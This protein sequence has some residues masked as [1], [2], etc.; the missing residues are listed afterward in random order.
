MINTNAI[1]KF[2]RNS[3]PNLAQSLVNSSYLEKIFFYPKYQKYLANFQNQL[4]LVTGNDGIIV[5]T[6][7]QRGIYITT[8]ESLAIPGTK[9]FIEA[10]NSLMEELTKI[11]EKRTSKF[12]IESNFGQLIKYPEIFSWGLENRLI[13]I[14]ASYIGT[15]IAYDTFM[16]HL[17]LS[18]GKE[19]ATR[20]WHI[21]NEDRK[22]IKIII[23]F[24]DVDENGGP[25]QYMHPKISSSLLQKVK[26]KY[27]FF[28]H[29]EI[30]ELIPNPKKDWLTTYTGKA[31]TVIIVDTA[32]SYHRGKPPT[33]SL[34]RAVTFG[35]LSRRPHQPFR[36]GRNLLS[37]EE[38]S[39]LAAKLPPEKQACV[40]W[41]DA[42]PTI[43]KLIPKYSYLY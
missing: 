22:V 9:E 39:L 6:L 30:E 29:Q 7:K 18:N 11:S 40:Y 25:F 32:H 13:N 24:N 14:V 5:E 12:A 43:V 3:L 15:P 36:A 2:L 31:G 26:D 37:R 1:R 21:D 19:T 4:P 42:L 20:R 17:S 33:K 23:Y 38:L 16:A 8:L 35:Y 27:H 41:Q 28:H 34:R 10:V